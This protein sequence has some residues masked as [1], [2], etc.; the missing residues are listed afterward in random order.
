[1]NQNG[2]YSIFALR[3]ALGWVFL[4]AGATKIFNTE[5]SAAG[6]LKIAKSFPGLF[7]WLASS[8]NIGWV[9]FLNEWGLTL[10]GISLITGILIKYASYGGI[11]LMA[12]YYLPVLDFPKVGNNSLI[13]DEHIIYIIIFS[14]LISTNAGEFLGLGKNSNKN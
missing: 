2:K 14:L 5:W 12:L 3:I 4:Y 10:V 6:Y 1:M 7:N 8:S 9:N 13:V 11:L